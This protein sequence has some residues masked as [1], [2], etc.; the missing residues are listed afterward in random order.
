ML[1]YKWSQIHMVLTSSY[2]LK[3]SQEEWGRGYYGIDDLIAPLKLMYQAS[4]SQHTDQRKSLIL[5]CVIWRHVSIHTFADT[6]PPVT[7][8]VNTAGGVM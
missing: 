7:A 4:N 1:D 8:V 6:L 3:Q 5:Y 2:C